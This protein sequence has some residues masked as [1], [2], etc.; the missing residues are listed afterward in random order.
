VTTSDESISDGV[1]DATMIINSRVLIIENDE[2]IREFMGELL[3]DE[4]YQVLMTYNTPAVLHVATFFDP[5][6][7]ILD[8][9]TAYHPEYKFLCAYK[10]SVQRHVPVIGM[11]TDNRL[12]A[13]SEM[14]RL[15]LDSFLPMPFD[16]EQFVMQVQQSLPC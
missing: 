1:K 4:G 9:G 2:P 8:I 13:Y 3:A 6:L 16:L 12:E 5:D 15:G 10:T 11:S 7:I 14:F